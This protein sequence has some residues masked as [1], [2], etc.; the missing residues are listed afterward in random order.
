MT[1][2]KLTYLYCFLSGAGL[3]NAAVAELR[4][5][6]DG[7]RN[8]TAA[9]DTATAHAMVDT[10]DRDIRIFMSTL[11]VIVNQCWTPAQRPR[12]PAPDRQA[13]GPESR[14]H[15]Q[16]ISADAVVDRR[17]VGQKPKPR[18]RCIDVAPDP[19]TDGR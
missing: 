9:I 18:R 17:V 14:A 8:Q 1:F 6:V 5:V 19:G 7:F 11:I 15:P 3:L 2:S 12:Y 16:G 10:E 4:K 13:R